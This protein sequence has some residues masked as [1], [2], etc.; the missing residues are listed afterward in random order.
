MKAPGKTEAYAACDAGKTIEDTVKLEIVISKDGAFSLAS[1]TPEL[2]DEIMACLA[3]VVATVK[4]RPIDRD[5]KM[6]YSL[7]LAPGPA[8]KISVTQMKLQ[9]I[10]T[11]PRLQDFDRDYQ[12]GAGL[13]AGGIILGTVSIVGIWLSWIPHL[14]RDGSDALLATSI[15]MKVFFALGTGAGIA[16]I[17]VGARKMERAL[18]QR[19][20]LFF[21]GLD[22]AP[23]A[24]GTGAVITSSFRF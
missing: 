17:V 16:M 4:M 8:A 12:K 15:F 22:L 24:G 23:T 2:G 19:N 14:M 13:L 20:Q 1:T 7:S 5:Y 21:S 6:V 11:D 18:I 3:A 10:L 9:K